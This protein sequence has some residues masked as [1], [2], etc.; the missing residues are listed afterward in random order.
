MAFLLAHHGRKQLSAYT[1][2]LERARDRRTEKR[3]HALRTSMKQLRT[4]LRL[5]EGIDTVTRPP[6]AALRRFLTLFKA[7]GGLREAQVST[8]L[9]S[10]TEELAPADGA[11]YLTHLKIERNKAGK[12]LKHALADIHTHDARKLGKYFAS[13][14]TDHTHT[15]E[16]RSA[17]IYVD[18]EMRMATTLLRA[19]AQGEDLHEVRKHL[20]NA[21]HTLRL[22]EDADTLTERQGA[23]LQRLGRIQDSL[24]DW[25][26]LHVVHDDLAGLA[27]QDEVAILKKAIGSKLRGQR[28]RLMRE[29][30]VLLSA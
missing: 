1:K 5:A 6:D 2:A 9:V 14:S 10:S 22:L 3:I 4:L 15:Q 20:K 18:R 30:R 11:V 8:R 27:Q 29:L 25:H 21:W 12:G 24:G 17:R 23:L 16:R 7:A 19:G 28:A 26:D 13:V